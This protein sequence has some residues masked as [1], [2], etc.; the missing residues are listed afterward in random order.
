MAHSREVR[1]PYLY[2]ELVA[3]CFLLPATF[4]IS[5]GYTKWVLRKGMEPFLPKQVIWRTDKIGFEPPQKQ[6]MEN[7]HVQELIAAAREKLVRQHV[8]HPSVLDKKIQ[9]QESHAADN[10]DWWRLS[11]GF[12]PG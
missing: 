1:L 3:F 9:P 10:I 6:W 11:A 8:L 7:S 12:L 5:E 4:K 2:H